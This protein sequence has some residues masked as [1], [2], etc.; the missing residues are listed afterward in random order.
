M[1]KVELPTDKIY[2]R[3]TSYEVWKIDADYFV[4]YWAKDSTEIVVNKKYIIS[5]QKY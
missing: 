2:Q 4:F 5:I 1:Y 3:I